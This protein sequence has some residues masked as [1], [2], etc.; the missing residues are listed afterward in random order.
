MKPI[1]CIA[2]LFSIFTTIAVAQPTSLLPEKDIPLGLCVIAGVEDPDL[3]A[4]LAQRPG[5]LTQQVVLT[6]AAAKPLRQAITEGK[7]Y[8]TTSV[9]QLRQGLNEGKKRNQADLQYSQRLVNTL[10]IDRQAEGW[11]NLP[12]EKIDTIMAPGGVVI[13]RLA[14]GWR[15]RDIPIP[16]TLGE[17][18]HASCAATNNPVSPDHEA[19]P[20][21]KVQWYAHHPIKGGVYLQRDSDQRIAGGATYYRVRALD[22]YH[23]GRGKRN[24]PPIKIICRDAMSGVLRWEVP[25]SAGSRAFVAV[26]DGLLTYLKP[27]GPLVLLDK[28][29]G[30]VIR[31]F[32]DSPRLPGRRVGDLHSEVASAE[33]VVLACG[34]GQ[35][36]AM[37][38][39][40]GKKL[41]SVSSSAEQQFF[42]ATIGNG[43][44]FIMEGNGPKRMRDL[45]IVVDRVRAFDLRSGKQ[46][47]SSA[48]PQGWVGSRLTYDNGRL[49]LWCSTTH[50]TKK[51]PGHSRFIIYDADSGRIPWRDFYKDDEQK[52]FTTSPPDEYKAERY[53]PLY[54]PMVRSAYIRDD[55]L[56][57]SGGNRIRQFNIRDG[58]PIPI[59]SKK[60]QWFKG[61]GQYKGT[62]KVPIATVNYHQLEFGCWYD[63][64][65]NGVVRYG[66]RGV[67]AHGGAIAYG[68]NYMVPSTCGCW[69]QVGHFVALS[70]QP[71]APRVANERRLQ[72]YPALAQVK[73]A[74]AP[75]TWPMPQAD[76]RAS[77][78]TQQ[79]LASVGSPRW[80]VKAAV[81]ADSAALNDMQASEYEWQLGAITGVTGG[82]GKMYYA[83]PNAQRID[84]RSLTNGEVLW[85]FY[86]NGALTAAPILTQGL[87]IFSSFDGNVYAVDANTGKLAWRF[88]AAATTEHI[89][90]H[91]QVSSAGPMY[92]APMLVGDDVYVASGIHVETEHGIDVYRLRASD[93]ELLAHRNLFQPAFATTV[94]FEF[95]KGRD[96]MRKK[97]D[98]P[99]ER[100]MRLRSD[101]KNIAFAWAFLDGKNLQSLDQASFYSTMDVAAVGTGGTFAPSL[102]VNYNRA[103]ASMS[104]QHRGGYAF[105]P[106]RTDGIQSQRIVIDNDR[107]FFMSSSRGTPLSL[108]TVSLDPFTGKPTA[109]LKKQAYTSE[110]VVQLSLGKGNFSFDSMI[111]ADSQIIIAATK[112]PTS[113]AAKSTLIIC[114]PD[115]GKT[116]NTIDLPGV[117]VPDGLSVIDGKL[118][119]ALTDGRV[120][121]Y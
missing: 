10:I 74:A 50:A 18:G 105:F 118:I 64:D 86:A 21:T 104:K 38:L 87:A 36:V 94:D 20:M 115:T 22:S 102:P 29:D 53:K 3:L 88:Y 71:V 55:I 8:A 111:M 9:K 61:F 4:T 31:T 82:N 27:D 103:Y 121:C 52:V 69:A 67:C 32:A 1:R 14:G 70:S 80:Q 35:L 59:G 72:R 39:A 26:A 96:P 34:S 110:S 89:V 47:W 92:G 44:A 108:H 117:V 2:I 101:G 45:R 106:D 113:K 68:M 19:G 66:S 65:L 25:V 16:D 41:W 60:T 37:D 49:L 77:A 58:S 56:Y 90:L 116:V 62:C 48:E 51:T 40:T 91:N 12:A 84:C 98:V 100:N 23:T 99:H 24:L 57:F 30:E 76:T 46:L 119:A 73:P 5:T 97:V 109:P 17:W 54:K 95:K 33:G 43:K 78:R 85:S 42:G 93:G 28:H 114:N 15:R 7:W 79:T 120:I 13:E 6:A 83:V 107:L 112:V 81:P 11:K 75:A 63:R